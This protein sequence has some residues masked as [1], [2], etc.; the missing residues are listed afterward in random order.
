[1]AYLYKH[2]P[3]QTNFNVN[4]TAWCPTENPEVGAP[5]RLDL[6]AMLQHFLDF[7]FEVVTRAARVRARAAQEAAPHPRGLREGLRRARR[8]DPDHPQVGGQGGRGGEADGA[9]QARRGA[10]RRDPRAQALQAG[11]A[12]DPGHPEG[13]RGE[14]RRGE[15]H[16]G[17]AQ[18]REEALGRGAATSS[19]EIKAQ[20]ADKRRTKIGGAG[21]EVEFAEEAFI[22]DEDANVVLTRDGWVKRVRELKDPTHHAPARGRRGDGGARRLAQG[23]PGA[24]SPTS[25]RPT[26]P[27]STTSRRRPATATR[28]RSSSSSTTASGS[29][30]RC[31]STRGCRSP[32]R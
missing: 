13:A 5:Q 28:C 26:S 9:L 1:M 20:Y 2:T 27:A 6:K 22:V 29:S 32:R 19:S 14:A 3:L 23:E 30:A 17:H 8:D 4:L 31:R 10:G 18:G 11:P 7:R 12:R 24:S 15:A 25:A 21:E 16:R